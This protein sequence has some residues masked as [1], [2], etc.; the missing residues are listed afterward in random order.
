MGAA[1]SGS[2]RNKKPNHIAMIGF[3]FTL[4]EGS[5]KKNQLLDFSFFVH[6]VLANY[7]IKFLDLKFAWHVTLVLISR[8][9]VT[10]TC[11]RY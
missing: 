5:S 7:W 6:N 1:R 11:R 10:S 2:S 3:Q 4:P 9:E 8:V